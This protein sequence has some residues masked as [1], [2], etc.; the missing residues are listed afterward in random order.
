M[1]DAGLA[2]EKMTASPGKNS[3]AESR[4]PSAFPETQTSVLVR[5]AQG[6]WEPFFRE[7]LAPCWREITQAC[8]GRV[9][10]GDAADLLQELTLRL[11]R[12]GR[13][14]DAEPLRGTIPQRFL[15]RKQLGIPSA[16]FRTYLKQVIANLVKEQARR[17]K[18]RT[19]TRDLSAADLSIEDSIHSIVDRYWVAACLAD[20][21][22]RFRDECLSAKTKGRRRQFET[23]YLATVLGLSSAEIG[24]RLG[25]HRTT[26]SEELAEARERFVAL[27]GTLSGIADR[28]ELKRYVAADPSRLFEALEI[29]HRQHGAM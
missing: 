25:L 14:R 23:L 1:T 26:A 15:V 12:M 8:R 18:E 9:P 2:W 6:D 24:K 20:A 16:K 13:S 7:Y 4:D 5:A 3:A 28:E 17:A 11:L 27:L 19:R 22:T 10:M 21:A 29:A